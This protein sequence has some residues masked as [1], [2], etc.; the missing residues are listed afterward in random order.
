MSMSLDAEKTL[1][2]LILWRENNDEIA[3]SYLFESNIGLI[4]S[5]AKKYY[6]SGLTIEELESI[7]TEGLVKAINKFN[8]IDKPIE[9]FTSY[10]ATSI[11]NQ[12]LNEIKK[13]NRNIKTLSF[14]TVIGYNKNGIELKLEDIIGTDSEKLLNDFINK[15]KLKA[16]KEVLRTL[17]L[18]ELQIIMLRYGFEGEQKTIIEISKI[19]GK[20]R[21]TVSIQEKKAL[22]KIRNLY[23][24]KIN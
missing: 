11:E 21:H 1:R 2:C 9:V 23:D 18:Q 22:I 12:I 24:K 4:K 17:T 14:E 7:G 20:N 5:I 6:N 16:L 19:L 15:M 3:A 13:N 10:I 8:Y